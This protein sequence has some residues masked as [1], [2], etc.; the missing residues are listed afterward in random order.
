MLIGDS[1]IVN[2]T[3][4]SSIFDKHFS[5]FHRLNFRIG[6]DKIQNVLWRINN[7]SL[8]PYLQYIFLF[9]VVQTIL[10][11]MIQRLFQMA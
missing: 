5:K 4:F 8:A 3:K 2:F 6:A 9:N 1:I 7:M 10:G 11:I